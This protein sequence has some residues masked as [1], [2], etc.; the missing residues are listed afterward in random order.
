MSAVAD[1]AAEAISE[2]VRDL[3]AVAASF[4]ELHK[5]PSEDVAAQPEGVVTAAAQAVP[6]EAEKI[7]LPAAVAEPAMAKPEAEIPRA[8]TKQDAQGAQES[9]S[10]IDA[11]PVEAK[12]ET[13]KIEEKPAE[14]K[15]EAAKL[16]E[17]DDS[18]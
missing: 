17:V 15:S 6:A 9:E 10:K 13:E 2:A 4:T 11:K 7:E 14:V 16:E 18:D 1:A 5:A 8:E 12:L 3:E